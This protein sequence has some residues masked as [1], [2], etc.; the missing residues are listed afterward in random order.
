MLGGKYLYIYI[1]SILILFSYL[2]LLSIF[3]GYEVWD[4]LNFVRNY[5]FNILL[6]IIFFSTRDKRAVNTNLL[7][8]I[9]IILTLIEVFLGLAQY[10]N[11]SIA[12]YFKITS[13]YRFG[14]VV[15]R[16]DF[17]FRNQKL[18]T[19][20]LLS[21]GNY[22]YFVVDTV[23]LLFAL[24]YFKIFNFSKNIY[25]LLFLSLI[26]VVFAGIK[27]PLFAF[28][29]G[30]FLILWYKEKKYAIIIGIAFYFLFF[31]YLSVVQPLLQYS[32]SAKG[33]A[34]L[35]ENPLDRIIGLF[36][37]SDSYYLQQTTFGRTM[38]LAEDSFNN[39]LIGSGVGV[40]FTE[41]SFTDAYLMVIVLEFGVIGLLLLLFP[42]IYTLWLLKKKTPLQ[43]YKIGKLLFVTILIQTIV[44]QGLWA[45]FTNI[46]F[47]LFIMIL[48]RLGKKNETNIISI[49]K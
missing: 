30:V 5:F 17:V 32:I 28:I 20:T 19:G 48:F 23:L 10:L 44:D 22:S 4:Y 11:R 37:I 35:I 34:S 15:E 26:V 3:W 24:K 42:Y 18:V 14:E 46:Q 40:I 21:M 8:K 36:A 27:A 29:V 25:Y 12:D 2:Y 38:F 9:I 16:L 41:Y 6:L 45:W 39:L 43:I 47:I 7:L 1:G 31:F 33:G 49:V 13:Y